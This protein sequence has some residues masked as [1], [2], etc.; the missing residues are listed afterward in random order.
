MYLH[1]ILPNSTVTFSC[2]MYER[3]SGHFMWWVDEQ[4]TSKLTEW[5]VVHHA[6]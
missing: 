4:K 6:T 2:E 3:V 1:S 5:E